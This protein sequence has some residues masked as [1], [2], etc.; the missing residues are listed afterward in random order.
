MLAVAFTGVT[1]DEELILGCRGHDQPRAL[2]LCLEDAL[3]LVGWQEQCLRR[4]ALRSPRRRQ[5]IASLGGLRLRLRCGHELSRQMVAASGIHD[6]QAVE[7]PVRVR[8]NGAVVQMKVYPPLADRDLVGMKLR[9]HG[10]ILTPGT[11]YRGAADRQKMVP[12]TMAPRMRMRRRTP[13]AGSAS[14]SYRVGLGPRSPPHRAADVPIFGEMFDLT[15]PSFDLPSANS[16]DI[17]Y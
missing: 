9:C 15:S 10:K 13:C 2:R 17:S 16:Q 1:G 14:G 11:A 5:Q 12:T 8:M 7:R 3:K 6:A 4:L